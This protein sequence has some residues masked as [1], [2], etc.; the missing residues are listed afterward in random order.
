MDDS[1]QHICAHDEQNVLKPELAGCWMSLKFVD[2]MLESWKFSKHFFL[3]VT[4]TQQSYLKSIGA[5]HNM[6]DRVSIH[7]LFT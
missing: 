2:A 1:V 3:E 7:N 5:N 6:I 4:L